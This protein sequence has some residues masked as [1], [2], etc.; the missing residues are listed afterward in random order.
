MPEE[1]LQRRDSQGH[2]VGGGLESSALPP[3]VLLKTAGL[4]IY[5]P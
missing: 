1:T 4:L 3:P 2:S 5:Q